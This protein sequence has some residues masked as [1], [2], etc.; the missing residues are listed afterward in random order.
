MSVKNF[1]AHETCDELPP[2]RLEL[3]C[4]CPGGFVYQLMDLPSGA[5]G[6]YRV[7]APEKTFGYDPGNTDPTGAA[8]AGPKTPRADTPYIDPS[9]PAS[10]D[11]QEAASTGDAAIRRAITRI[12]NRDGAG[13]VRRIDPAAVRQGLA[14]ARQAGRTA[15]ELGRINERNA[16]FYKKP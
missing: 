8:K 5:M 4:V 2:E 14:S 9:A 10:P 3:M 7:R 13:N 11:E 6:V 16:E 1:T 15:G 12:S